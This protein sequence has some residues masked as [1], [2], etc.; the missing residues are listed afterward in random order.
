MFITPPPQYLIY[1][2]T[3]L[4]NGPFFPLL[5]V[6]LENELDDE[7][8]HVDPHGD[9]YI[10]QLAMK[11]GGGGGGGESE[12]D[13]S[14]M[15]QTLT[16]IDYE[17]VIDDED[18]VDEFLL[19]KNTL[20]TLSQ[21]DPEWYSLLTS[22]LSPEQT[23]QVQEFLAIAD[24]RV[25]AR[26]SRAIEQQGGYQFNISVVPNTFAFGAEGPPSNSFGGQS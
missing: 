9:Q 16:E 1:M 17:T 19:F 8:D 20:H 2:E 6:W 4:F 7:E 13:D 14:E 3:D 12:S 15:A 5:Y 21:Q 24:K 18:V 26:Q 22:R 23:V 10:Q 25:A 11:L